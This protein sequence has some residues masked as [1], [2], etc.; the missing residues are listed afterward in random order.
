[1]WQLQGNLILV[2]DSLNTD[3]I[4]SGKSHKNLKYLKSVTLKKS[5]NVDFII[6]M[7]FSLRDQLKKSQKPRFPQICDFK[8]V[9]K[10]LFSSFL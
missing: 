1:M 7:T 2:R 3:A 6:F 8:K 9:T 5:Q 10:T 4:K